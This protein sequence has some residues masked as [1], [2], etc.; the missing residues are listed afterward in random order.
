MKTR[1][2]ASAPCSTHNNSTQ[3]QQ[4]TQHTE[5]EEEDKDKE[6]THATYRISHPALQ[7]TTETSGN[8]TGTAEAAR[9]MIASE[10]ERGN[11]ADLV[12]SVGLIRSGC[13]SRSNRS[14]NS[15]GSG[16]GSGT[17]KGMN[18]SAVSVRGKGTIL[19][20]VRVQEGDRL[21][22]FLAITLPLPEK[23]AWALLRLVDHLV[24]EPPHVVHR[25]PPWF[26]QPP[27]NLQRAKQQ[28]ATRRLRTSA[29]WIQ[30]RCRESSRR[31]AATGSRSLIRK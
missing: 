22:R 11:V 4:P 26:L 30:T 12:R 23:A 21:A 3:Q 29:I 8:S 31:K 16:R 1:S 17:E 19:V 15:S 18:G 9:R 20:E 28:Q 14:S 10:N 5:E 24:L 7:A 27:V 25:K 2:N 6:A 13:A